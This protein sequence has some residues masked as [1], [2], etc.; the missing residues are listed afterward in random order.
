[1][2]IYFN[3]IFIA[4]SLVCTIHWVNVNITE[5]VQRHAQSQTTTQ[6]VPWFMLKSA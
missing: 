4:S 6:A 3:V 2:F 1:M 5:A